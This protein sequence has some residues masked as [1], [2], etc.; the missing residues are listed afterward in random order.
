MYYA[1]VVLALELFAV[2]GGQAVAAVSPSLF[3]AS[4][5]NPPLVMVF[6]LFCGVTVPKPNLP[7]F[8]RECKFFFLGRHLL[9]GIY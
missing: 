3:I 1:I 9:S 4:K 7:K 6:A 5:A 2:T 8:W